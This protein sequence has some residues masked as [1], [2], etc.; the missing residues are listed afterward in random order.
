LAKAAPAVIEA[1]PEGDDGILAK[2]KTFYEKARSF[3]MDTYEE[4]KLDLRFA[5]LEEQWHEQDR[6]Q[7]EVDRRPCET[8]N[9]MASFIRQVVNDA[10]QNKPAIKVHPADDQADPETALII[11]GLIRNIE[12]ISNADAA[13]DTGIEHAADR[14]VGFWRVNTRYACDDTFEQDIIIERITNPFSVYGDYRTQTVD[15]SDW[16]EAIIATILSKEEFKREYPKAEKV[17]WDFDFQGLPDWLEGDNVT[18][19]EY[20][21]REKVESQIIALS[22]GTVEKVAEVKRLKADLEASGITE[23]G[24]PRTVESY[25]VT[26]YILSGAEVLKTVEWAGRYIP[27][28]PVYGDEIVDEN[29]KRLFRSLIH[30]A[31]GAQR[32]YNYMRNQGIELVGLAPKAPFIGPKGAFNGDPNWDTANQASHPYLEYEGG[33][34][35]QRAQGVGLHPGVLQEVLSA[36]SDMKDIIGL[37][38]AALGIRSN[39]TSGKA[40][41]ERKLE[42]DTATF[43]FGDN[44]N[45][46]IRHTGLVLIDLIPKVYPPGRI[47]RVLGEDHQPQIVKTGEPVPQVG[48]DGQPAQ[49]ETGNPIMRV[50]DLTL[51]KYDLTVSSGPSY[52]SRREELSEHLVAMAQAGGETVAAILAPRIAKLQDIP[53]A[54]EIAKELDALN[55]A[56]KAM[57]GPQVPPEVQEQMQQGMQLI[58]QQG[59]EIEQ[60][61]AGRAE[62]VAELQLKA[63]AADQKDRE[64]EIKA[65]EAETARLQAQQPQFLKVSPTAQQGSA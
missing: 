30:G 39:E 42:G 37:Q 31:K 51:G 11:N 43:H 26:Q 36:D 17:N 56:K 46:A 62:K 50:Y 19:A 29:G 27:I 3:W 14:S 28:I 22:D 52:T 6:K 57:Q 23:V 64:L 2:A 18:V 16:N 13:Y 59:Q 55:P 38:N 48:K 35:P 47:L 54:D 8:F 58:Q 4:G 65:Y 20:W 25:K 61:K 32:M 40:I 1:E 9:K 21:V 49:D 10:R 63:R 45:R 12:V 34:A 7:R 24:E 33:T 60:L 44:Q 15:S 5:R 53:D 41:R